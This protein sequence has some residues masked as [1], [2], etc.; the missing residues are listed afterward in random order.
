MSAALALELVVDGPL[1]IEP[2]PGTKGRRLVVS[3]LLPSG[4]WA[5]SEC[6]RTVPALVEA[7]GLVSKRLKLAKA[8]SDAT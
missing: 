3:G 5:H 6:A 7:I 1:L 4:M 8:V 2:A